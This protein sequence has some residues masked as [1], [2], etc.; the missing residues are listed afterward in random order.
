LLSATNWKLVK[1][2]E[3]QSEVSLKSCQLDDIYVFNSE[4]WGYMDEGATK[5]G[6]PAP[7]DTTAE[8][9]DTSIVV[10][11]STIAVADDL[12]YDESG[13]RINFNWHVSGDQFELL[14]R[15]FGHPDNDPVWQF[16]EM[17][18]R[19]FVVSGAER[20]NGKVITYIK[21]FVAL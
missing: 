11:R 6:D 20:R 12:Q 21:E 9:V 8:P 3:N 19:R 18:A 16:M 15:D 10:S 1:L 4:G 2:I 14:I 7:V 13:M 17:D 5:C